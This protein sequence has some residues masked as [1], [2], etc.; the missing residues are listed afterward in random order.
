VQ[1]V[2][3]WVGLALAVLGGA[4]FM[5]SFSFPAVPG[6][7]VGA[8]FL[9]GLVGAGL[10]LCGV[11]LMVRS[12]RAAAYAGAPERAAG[13]ERYPAAAV[14]IGAMLA[15]IG[16]ADLLGFLIVTPFVLVALFL[17]FRVRLAP[18]LLWAAVGTVVVHVAFY[19][20]LRVPLP[21]GVLR[22]LY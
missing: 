15:Y 4:V 18:A 8:G 6:Q 5:S 19:K 3:R 20:L 2:D 9:P 10:A 22:P 11:A 17:V 21:W 7:K 13:N 12:L 1:R 14:V 16:L